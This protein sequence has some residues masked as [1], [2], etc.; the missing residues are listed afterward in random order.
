MKIKV[1]EHGPFGCLVYKGVVDSLEELPDNYVKK[2]VNDETGVIVYISPLK[3][4]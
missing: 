3:M 2:V 1:M 4:Q